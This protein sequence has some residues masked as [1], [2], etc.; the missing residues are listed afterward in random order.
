[1]KRNT[2][3]ILYG[4]ILLIVL[5]WLINYFFNYSIERSEL[6]EISGYLQQVPKFEKG[7]GGWH[8]ELELDSDQYRYQT[9]GLSYDALDKDGVKTEIT[10]GSRIQILVAKNIGFEEMM[11]LFVGIKRIYGLKSNNKTYL[12][13]D[14][15]NHGKKDTRYLPL[16]IWLIFGGM[17]I[18]S[19]WIKKDAL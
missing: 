5:I 6:T 13:L 8:M 2:K 1:M 9:D 17:Y 15:Y 4:S 3:K 14:N 19:F 18:Y 16:F 10:A 12:K 11:N 7:K